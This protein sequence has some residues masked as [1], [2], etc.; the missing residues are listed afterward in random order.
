MSRC[1]NVSN[2]VADECTGI[3]LK[4]YSSEWLNDWNVMVIIHSKTKLFIK[5]A[6]RP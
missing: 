6:L 5:I 2:K 3:L 4:L 1:T